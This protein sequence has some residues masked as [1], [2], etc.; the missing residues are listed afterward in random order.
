M[1][2]PRKDD[3]FAP[4]KRQA[5]RVLA[6]LSQEIQKRE[7]ELRNL[8]SQAN[9]WRSILGVG[10][11]ALHVGNGAGR[12]GRRPSAAPAR[13]SAGQRVDWDQVLATV[14]KRFG[15]DHVLRHPGAR[16][17]GRAQIYPA[18]T[19]WE[20]TKKI[21]RVGKGQYEKVAGAVK[22]RPA[23]PK[24]QRKARKGR[25]AVAAKRV[26]SAKRPA[27]S[28]KGNGR[29][30]WDSV[31]KGLPKTFGAAD[32]MKHPVAAAKGQGQ[33]FAAIGRWVATKRA[34][35]VGKGQYQRV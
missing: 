35:K 19:R 20:A 17:K 29:V 26:A 21:R 34:K 7:A 9:N 27:R 14:P 8:M 10:G 25:A 1:P 32:L 33:V 24:A 4:M 18:L 28:A 15:V 11:R 6:T 16:S 2:R 3:L 13:R 31:L 23:R 30:D 22:A 5:A 12:R